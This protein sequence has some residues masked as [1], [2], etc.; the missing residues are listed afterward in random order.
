MIMPYF[1]QY[2]TETGKT[3]LL[4]IQSSEGAIDMS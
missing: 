4:A 2:R 3:V 1:A